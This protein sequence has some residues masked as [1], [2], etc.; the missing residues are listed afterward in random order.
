MSPSNHQPE[1]ICR[2]SYAAGVR[3]HTSG[4]PGRAD[5]KRH[6]SFRRLQRAGLL[7]YK[8]SAAGRADVERS[9]LARA[10]LSKMASDIR[11]VVYRESDEEQE[12]GAET[13]AESDESSDSDDETDTSES[14]VDTAESFASQDSGVYGDLNSLVIHISRPTRK[15]RAFLS[16]AADDGQLKASGGDLKSVSY[17]L[18]GVDSGGLQE[19]AAEISASSSSDGEPTGGLARLEGDRL[20]MDLADET[21]R[22]ANTRLR[23]RDPGGGG[24]VR[25]VPV[26]RRTRMGGGMGQFG[27]RRAAQCH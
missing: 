3:V 11:C 19:L 9:Q 1:E 27:I 16:T 2:A 20:A 14:V 15:R 4:S 25:R 7:H 23:N 18:A 6:S 13:A 17:F 22:P 24:R 26:L 21:G 5:A 10:L 12:D 8:Y